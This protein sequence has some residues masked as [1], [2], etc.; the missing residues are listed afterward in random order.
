MSDGRSNNGGARAGSG[1]KKG[2]GNNIT[3]SFILEAL[4]DQY[5]VKK[6]ETAQKKFI[7]DIMNTERGKLFIAEHLFGKAPQQIDYN[8]ISDEDIIKAKRQFI[9]SNEEK[10]D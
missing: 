1:R 9:I 4:K 7:K 10:D 3:R 6:D 2:S 8:D 5:K